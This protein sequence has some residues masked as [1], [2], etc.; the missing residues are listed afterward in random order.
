MLFGL[1][2][3]GVTD[4]I[5]IENILCGYFKNPDLD[6]EITELQPPFDET[7]QKHGEGGWLTLLKYLASVRFRED[8]LNTEFIILQIDSD[9]AHKIPVNHKDDNGNELAAEILISDISVKLIESI[10]TGASGFYQVHAT[11]IIFAICVHSLECW[12][13]AHHAEQTAIHDCFEVLKTAI[14]PNLIRVAKKHK[15]YDKL[16]QPFLERENIDAVAGKDPSFRVFI[17]ELAKIE[18][19]IKPKLD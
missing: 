16:S 13:V 9:I 19:R 2:C 6:Q 10:N 5:T 17:Q 1:A 15:N 18:G 7:D 11:K 4:Q 12:L 3:E 14:N 8:V